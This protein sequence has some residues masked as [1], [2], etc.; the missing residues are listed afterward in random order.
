LADLKDQ[1]GLLGADLREMAALRWQ[2]A[3]LEFEADLRAVKRLA[4]TMLAAAVMALS[5]LPLLAVWAAQLLDRRLG[6]RFAGWLLLFG[7]GLLLGG[8]AAGYLAWRRFRAR[9]TAMEQTREELREDLVW[10]REWAGRRGE[11]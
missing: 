10:L 3:R 11:E 5:A 9:F 4:A 6:I 2:L 8:A 1:L 7:L